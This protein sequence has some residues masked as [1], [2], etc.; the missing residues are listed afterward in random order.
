MISLLRENK[1]TGWR[2]KSKLMGKPDFIFPREKIA[3]FVDGCFWHGH[4]SLCRLPKT[5]RAY[6]SAKIAR[7]KKRDLEVSRSLKKMG[8]T[9]IR[10]WENELKRSNAPTVQRR[11]QRTLNTKRAKKRYG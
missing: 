7:N 3:I 5:N 10:I 11:I 8:W 4:H 1:I 6:W 9:V 2:R